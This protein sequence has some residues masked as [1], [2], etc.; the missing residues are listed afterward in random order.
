MDVIIPM[1]TPEELKV[2]FDNIWIS[3]ANHTP[4][5]IAAFAKQNNIIPLEVAG[6]S[7]LRKHTEQ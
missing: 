4:Q 7:V 6:Q 3:K 2:Y 5:N 1:N